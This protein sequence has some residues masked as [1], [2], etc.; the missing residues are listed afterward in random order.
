MRII[1]F[2]ENEPLVKKILTHLQLWGVKHK[3]PP[4]VTSPPTGSFIIY[5][6]NS[7]PGVD[8]YLIDAGYPVDL[9]RRS[10]TCWVVAESEA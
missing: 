9:P 5:D 4:R 10:S 1:S 7:S 2:I 6:E 8:D 3:P